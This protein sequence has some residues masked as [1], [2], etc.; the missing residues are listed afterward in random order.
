AT[1]TTSANGAAIVNAGVTARARL[2]ASADAPAP[3]VDLYLV[4]APSLALGPGQVIAVDLQA[5]AGT[6]QVVG[7]DAFLDFDPTR[8]EI[9]AIDLA[10]SP[11]DVVLQRTWVNEAGHVN[12][13]LGRLVGAS[14]AGASGYFRVARVTFRAAPGFTA[15]SSATTA[16]VTF[17]TDRAAN[18]ETAVLTRTDSVLRQANGATIALNPGAIAVTSPLVGDASII[19]GIPASVG[20]TILDAANRPAAGVAYAV[21]VRGDL[22]LVG[23]ATGTTSANGAAIAQVKGATPGAT[24]LVAVK[25][26]GALAQ[27]RIV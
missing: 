16:P 25:V 2:M 9:D 12:L 8:V 26:G 22:A 19:A 23:P 4:G 6:S 17:A 1:G 5:W 10:G 13:S 27:A 18:R 14:G 3:S 15:T 21:E 7:I 11:F 20:F 24:G